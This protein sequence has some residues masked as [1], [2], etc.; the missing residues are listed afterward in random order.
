[1]H[2]TLKSDCIIADNV[3]S[4]TTYS[5]L[6]SNLH[7]SSW[8]RYFRRRILF[9]LF[10]FFS[11]CLSSNFLPLINSI[12]SRLEFFFRYRIFVA[13]TKSHETLYHRNMS[14][15]LASTGSSAKNY[16]RESTAARVLGSG[17]CQ[18]LAIRWD[19]IYMPIISVWWISL[20]FEQQQKKMIDIKQFWANAITLKVPL[21]LLNWQSSILYVVHSISKG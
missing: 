18:A 14:P 5:G 17:M 12:S 15:T 8:N 10:F 16:K 7:K 3:L 20:S 4:T 13:P 1:M 11:W 9:F 2:S 6:D 21:V 19:T